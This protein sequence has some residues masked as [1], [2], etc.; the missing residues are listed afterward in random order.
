MLP[1]LTWTLKMLFW[2][3]RVYSELSKAKN[4]KQKID[5]VLGIDVSDQL[6]NQVR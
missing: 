4:S 5:I 2:K 1:D 3:L 6:V